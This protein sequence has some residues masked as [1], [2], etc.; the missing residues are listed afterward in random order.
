MRGG[1]NRLAEGQDEVRGVTG[2]RGALG[3]EGRGRRGQNGR[4][5][6]G[7]ENKDDGGG[8]DGGEQMDAAEI[9]TSLNSHLDAFFNQTHRSWSSSPFPIRLFLF[10][11]PPF[12]YF[13]VE[14]FCLV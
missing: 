14:L 13:T 7:E 3:C 1:V 12:L 10:C 6:E 8:I 2:G 9:R 11:P 4:G 5:V